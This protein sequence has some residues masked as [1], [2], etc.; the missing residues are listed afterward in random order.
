MLGDEDGW[1]DG[2]SSDGIKEYA[3]YVAEAAK[4]FINAFIEKG[5][6]REEALRIVIQLLPKGFNHK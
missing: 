5:F 4:A 6:T 1:K 3:N 2:V